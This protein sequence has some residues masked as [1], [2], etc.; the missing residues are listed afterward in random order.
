M[1]HAHFFLIPTIFFLGFFL[2]G[3]LNQRNQQRKVI[4][5]EPEV[6]S[7]SGSILLNSWPNSG[8]ALALSFGLVFSV[9]VA[10]HMF[11]FFG[12]SKVLDLALNGAPI[13]DKLP[14]FSSTE[15]A[16]RLNGMGEIGRAMYQRFTYTADL[17]FP[18]SL[19]AFLFCLTRFVAARSSLTETPRKMLLLL[20]FVWFASDMLENAIVFTLIAQLPT[21]NSHLAGLLGFVT[22]SKFGLLLLTIVAASV[23]SVMYQRKGS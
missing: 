7:I 21:I 13:F 22:V 15:V 11:A 6:M 17:A 4:E 23:V 16:D 20:P 12:G 19:L 10:T 8:K 3:F 14:S 18:M 5:Q 2:G 1:T 9:F